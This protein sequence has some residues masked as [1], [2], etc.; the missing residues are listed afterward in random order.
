[1]TDI[2]PPIKQILE[3]AELLGIEL[4]LLKYF[5]KLYPPYQNIIADRVGQALE[6]AKHEQ[7]L[8]NKHEDDAEAVCAYLCHISKVNRRI[9]IMRPLHTEKYSS[10]QLEE[11]GM[12]GLYDHV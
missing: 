2:T 3:E 4:K 11:M 12:V 5:D 9:V 7:F 6:K 8:T 10:E 1:M